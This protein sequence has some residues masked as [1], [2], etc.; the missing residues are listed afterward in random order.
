[1][2]GMR[3]IRRGDLQSGQGNIYRSMSK[4]PQAGSS[5]SSTPP[6]PVDALL[7]KIARADRLGDVLPSLHQHAVET[8]GG[9][10]SILFE[11]N[12]R[13]GTLHATSAHGL[14]TLHPEPWQP[15]G[16]EGR[17]VT[18]SFGRKTPTLV[19]DLAAQMPDLA[20]RL[21]PA[22]E[23]ALVPL[24]IGDHR[25]GLLA[26]GFVGLPSTSPPGPPGEG[27]AD[28][29]DA[30]RLALELFGL[31]Q[32]E[33]LGR[34]LRALVDQFSVSLAGTLDLAVSLD[35]VCQGIARLFG[36]DRASVWLHD[37]RL[38]QL[39][40][41][42]STDARLAAPAP[43]IS[44]EDPRI[45]ASAAL[46]HI[47]AEMSPAAEGA[48][49]SD[50]TIPLRGARRAL[51]VIVLE[52]ARIETGGELDLLD[53]ADELGRRLSAAVENVQLI[54]HAIRAGATPATESHEK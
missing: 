35:I 34:D 45:L 10:S 32:R 50:V 29:V 23:A 9:S 1:M 52:G 14:E 31:R 6:R 16:D 18:L 15:G 20:R 12:A 17:L 11:Y 3:P 2:E 37:R 5:E 40:L 38:Q 21:Q 27:W 8:V 33:A 44:S 26:I 48:S 43:R 30:C 13:R 28:I 4:Q 54:E 49:T 24:T 41:R 46:R 39:E 36:A 7:S 42:A 19:S 53:R 51:G 22:T 47:R 25:A